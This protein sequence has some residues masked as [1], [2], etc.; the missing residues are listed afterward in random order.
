MK[1]TTSNRAPQ[2]TPNGFVPKQKVSGENLGHKL[3]N[4]GERTRFFLLGA[5][6]SSFDLVE[7]SEGWRLVPT[8]KRLVIQAGVNFT[9]Q[10][11]EGQALDSSDIEA[12][13][14]SRFGVQVLTDPDQYMYAADGAAG[15]KGHFLLWENV[16]TYPDGTYEVHMDQDGYDR[17][18]WS[19]VADGIVP[20][21]RDSIIAEFTRRLRKQAQRATRT[22]HLMQAQE[23][24]ALAERRQQGLAEAQAALA[25]LLKPQKGAA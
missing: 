12:K 15:Q 11:K 13:F 25:D 19:L 8:L 22:P 17:W 16:K 6:P 4:F 1:D 9:R 24:K 20:P 23:A 7:T 18:R 2:A 14:R 10:V 21:P 5:H 3:P